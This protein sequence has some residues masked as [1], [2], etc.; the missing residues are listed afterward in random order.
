MHYLLAYLNER[1]AEIAARVKG[2]Q[3][4]DL[5]AITLGEIDDIARRY[6]Q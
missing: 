1:H 2:A 5:S 3:D 4:A 6:T